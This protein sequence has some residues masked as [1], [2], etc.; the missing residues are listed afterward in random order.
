MKNVCYLLVGMNYIINDMAEIIQN[1]MKDKKDN[2]LNIIVDG[3][4]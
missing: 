2:S 4:D 3:G 1:K